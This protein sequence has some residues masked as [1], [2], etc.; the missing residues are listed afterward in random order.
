AAAA[1]PAEL[2]AGKKLFVAVSDISEISEQ[3]VVS[4][5]T[6]PPPQPAAPETEL[7]HEMPQ[8]GAVS[9][10][11]EISEPPPPPPEQ[12]PTAEP[13]PLPT[14]AQAERERDLASLLTDTW[15]L[16]DTFSASDAIGGV[17]LGRG[18]DG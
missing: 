13:Y 1:E 15:S 5:S 16:A 3:P 14:P 8:R 12:P 4:S 6:E 2:L 10:I 17:S 18:L 7:E 9:E 11:S